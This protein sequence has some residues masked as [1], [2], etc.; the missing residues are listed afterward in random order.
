MRGEELHALHTRPAGRHRQVL[1]FVTGSLLVA[2]TLTLATGRSQPLAAGGPPVGVQGR[3]AGHSVVAARLEELRPLLE[4]A[5]GQAGVW[6]FPASTPQPSRSGAGAPRILTYTVRPGDT[7]WQVARNFQTD[8]ETIASLNPGVDPERI[9]P[10]DTLRIAANFKGAVHVVQPGDNLGAI[11]QDYGVTVE[12]IARANQLADANSL[13]VGQVLL[14]PGGR[15]PVRPAPSSGTPANGAGGS[16]GSPPARG[17]SGRFIWPLSG[18]VTSEFGPRWG[19]LHTGLDIAAPPGTPVVA[20]RSGRVVFA[21]WDG[22]YGLC[23]ILDHGDGTRTRYAHASAILRSVG[24]WVEQGQPVIRVG[25]TGFSTGPHL[26]FE[27][28]V[29]GTPVDPRPYLP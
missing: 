1:L 15:R 8:E 25:T 7:L 20:A 28:I 10:G 6:Q 26:H 14:V 2:G 11:A 18:P 22:G 21:G 4:G 9:Q 13:Q 24:E 23:L 27:I 17:A 5:G 3:S 16:Q 29:N 12:A 19:T